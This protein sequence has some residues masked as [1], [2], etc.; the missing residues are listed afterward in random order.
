MEISCY[1]A[2]HKVTLEQNKIHFMVTLLLHAEKKKLILCTE[3]F[4]WYSVM[5]VNAQLYLSVVYL[6]DCS[7]SSGSAHVTHGLL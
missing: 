2:Q 7:H 5:D 3:Q 4:N 6:Q 1:N